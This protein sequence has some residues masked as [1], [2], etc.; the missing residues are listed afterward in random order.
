[1]GSIRQ[2]IIAT[3]EAAAPRG[4]IFRLQ[5]RVT[6]ENLVTVGLVAVAVASSLGYQL[7]RWRAGRSDRP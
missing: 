3:T 5:A 7:V 1:M 4:R 2:A 6:L